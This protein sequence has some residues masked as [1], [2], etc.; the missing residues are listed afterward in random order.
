MKLSDLSDRVRKY[1]R[2]FVVAL[3]ALVVYTVAGSFLA[4][5]VAKRQLVRVAHD[6][7]GLEAR[8]ERLRFNPYTFKVRA[9]GFLLVE[10]DGDEL[11]R[12]DELVVNFQ[13]SSM[14]RWGGPSPTWS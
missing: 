3:A 7:L 9:E 2:S 13:L 4:P 6:T 14:F 10:A 5:W 1:R 8:L 12:F 11:L